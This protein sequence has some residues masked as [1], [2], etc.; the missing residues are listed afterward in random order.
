MVRVHISGLHD[1]SPTELSV[2][3]ELHAAKLEELHA[4]RARYMRPNPNAVVAERLAGPSRMSPLCEDCHWMQGDGGGQ[5]ATHARTCESCGRGPNEGVALHNGDVSK[6]KVGPGETPITEKWCSHC[7][8]PVTKPD[9][10][11]IFRGDPWDSEELD[12]TC[13]LPREVPQYYGRDRADFDPLD[14][15][16]DILPHGR[17][18][19]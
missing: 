7:D 16:S 14:D 19:K 15:K 4:A 2:L 10:D 3:E 1:F 17:T 18:T 12:T 9:A 6:T 13:P 11:G 5:C 8:P